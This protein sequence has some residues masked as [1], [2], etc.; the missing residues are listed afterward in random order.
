MTIRLLIV[1][2]H[3]IVRDGLRGVFDGD[4]DFEVAG[5]AGDGAE[6][7]H[8]AL[9]LGVDVVLMDLR[10]PGTGGVEAIGLLRERAPDIR[11]LVLT[12]YD[13]DADVLPAIE[14]GATGYLLKDAPREEL[15]RAVR[16]AHQG[17]AVLAP[18]VAQKLL[19][20]MRRPTT[21]PEQPPTDRELEVLR[22]VAAGTTNKDAARRLFI[23]EATVKTH[24]LHLYAKLGV[25]DR[26]AAV[27]EGY[28]K[29]L[30][31]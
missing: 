8:R 26:A 22:L 30:L 18:T 6:G 13:S 3:P 21:A 10:M 24:L 25:R 19:T 23:S 27:A 12:T 20:H 7:V 29:G 14:A 16:A 15:V 28:R 4:P 2:D 9:A 1:D 5:E 17:Q 31:S 11:V